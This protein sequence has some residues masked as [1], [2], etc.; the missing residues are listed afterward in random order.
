MHRVARC[1]V[2]AL[3]VGLATLACSH[4]R[5]RD[6]EVI[7]PPP[8]QPFAKLLVLGIHEDSR[9]RRLFEN[10]F[11]AEL[12]AEK[13]DGVQSYKFIYEER[14]INVTNGQEIWK[15]LHFVSG[16]SAAC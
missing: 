6:V 4:T 13:V 9:I 8:A 15:N 12:A 16:F 5:V 2:L 7:G 1:L 3:L 14:A 11:V 10:A